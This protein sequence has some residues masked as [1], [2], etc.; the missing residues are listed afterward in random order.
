MVSRWMFDC[1]S[2]HLLYVRA[3]VHTNRHI[4]GL[5]L[6]GTLHRVCFSLSMLPNKKRG[7]CWVYLT[8]VG[9]FYSFICPFENI[10]LR[11]MASICPSVNFFVS[12]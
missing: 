9:Y 10:M 6:V 1:L 7:S 5:R 4:L 8:N 3:S 11:R 2:I 12:G